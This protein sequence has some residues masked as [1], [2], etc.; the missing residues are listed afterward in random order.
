MFCREREGLAGENTRLRHRWVST[1][2]SSFLEEP[3]QS[4]SS[5]FEKPPHP[6]SL[7]SLGILALSSHHLFLQ[8]ILFYDQGGF[9][10]ALL[11]SLCCLILFFLICFLRLI[12]FKGQ[13]IICKP[14]WLSS[15]S[16][17]ILVSFTNPLAAG[18][19]AGNLS[20]PAWL[21]PSRPSGAK[22]LWPTPPSI[23]G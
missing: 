23:T 3:R 14:G 18:S 8:L 22:A 19:E 13:L 10:W 17:A 4:S 9:P 11:S 6:P 16:L 21:R 2:F 12:L 20:R 1:S 15:R 7:R 5:F